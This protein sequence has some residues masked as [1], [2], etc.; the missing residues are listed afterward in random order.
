[1]IKNYISKKPK[2]I[3]KEPSEETIEFLLSYSKSLKYVNS[4]KFDTQ[5]ELNLN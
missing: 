4:I 2:N 5:V 3:N 1:M